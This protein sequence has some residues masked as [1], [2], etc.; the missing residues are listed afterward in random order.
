M[1]DK[2]KQNHLEDEPHKG[3]N[4][5]EEKDLFDPKKDPPYVGD[6]ISIFSRITIP[7]VLTNLLSYGTVV[8][9]NIFAGQMEDS[10]NLAVIGLTYTIS[11]IIM[12][13]LLI[14]INAAQETLT[15]QAYGANNLQLTGI[16]LNRGR[17][18]L[19]VFYILLAIWPL[20]YGEKTFLALGMDA[21]VSKS[22]QR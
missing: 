16:Y 22:T 3:K 13:M 8:N 6:M 10:R 4:D 1:R 7:A 20:A 18:I 17:V 5:I 14:G 2:D 9:D 21:E 12:Y 11:I 15:S 19:T